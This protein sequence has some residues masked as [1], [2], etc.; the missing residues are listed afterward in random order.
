MRKGD[1]RCPGI[2]TPCRRAGRWL[3]THRTG[4][5][6]RYCLQHVLELFATMAE[7]AAAR[8]DKHNQALRTALQHLS[9][10][11]AP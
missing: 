1:T 7:S 2:S 11:D 8:R 4:T 3:W 5:A 10:E 6:E 9:K